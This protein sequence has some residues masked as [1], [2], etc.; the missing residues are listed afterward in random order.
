MQIIDNP[1]FVVYLYGASYDSENQKVTIRVPKPFFFSVRPFTIK[2]KSIS[3]ADDDNII[4]HYSP[5]RD[6]VIIC[7]N[8]KKKKLHSGREYSIMVNSQSLSEAT[9]ADLNYLK[10]ILP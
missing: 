6:V 2:G 8:G 9:I 5:K 4:F 7:L 10:Q 3:K 1:I